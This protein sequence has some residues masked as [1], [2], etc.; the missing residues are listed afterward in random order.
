MTEKKALRIFEK[1]NPAGAV[2]RCPNGRAVVRKQ[3]DLY[4][5]AAVNLYGIISL[6]D[7]VRIFNGQNETDTHNEEVFSLLLPIVLKQKRYCFFDDCIVHYWAMDDF[8]QAEYLLREQGDKPRYVP[9]KDELLQYESEY[10]ESETQDKCWRRL[11]EFIFKE[12]PN[13][14]N[15]Y[16]VYNGLKNTPENSMGLK[17]SSELLDKYG[18][19]FSGDKQ[20]QKFFDLLMDARNNTR[21]WLNK[22]YSPNELME[23]STSQLPKGNSSEIVIQER[24][25]VGRNDPCPCRSEKK[26][27]HCCLLTEESRTAQLSRSERDLFYTT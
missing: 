14:R 6:T 15:I 26:Y 4:A 11:K 16:R 23:I 25:K 12:W 27:K 3:L 7:F 19:A 10:Y 22:G 8:G 21:L 13:N 17:E 1:Y 5:Q 2:V 20:M 18:L 9:E 24:K